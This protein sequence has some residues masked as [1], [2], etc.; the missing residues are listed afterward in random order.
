M[1]N[2]AKKLFEKS[3]ADAQGGLREDEEMR[4][5]GW[6]RRQACVG[7]RLRRLRRL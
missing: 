5:G 3:A 6:R 7:W 4:R 2:E 1:K